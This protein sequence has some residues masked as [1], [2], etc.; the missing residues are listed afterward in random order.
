MEKRRN[1]IGNPD[2]GFLA[3]MIGSQMSL[4]VDYNQAR[5]AAHGIGRHGF[6]HCRVPWLI[7]AD[8][9]ML[10]IFMNESHE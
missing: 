1:V 3:K 2:V 5:R 4:T 7:P 9:E 8:W 6:R 10:I